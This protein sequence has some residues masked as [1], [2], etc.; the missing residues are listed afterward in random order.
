M[1]DKYLFP[2]LPEEVYPGPK[3]SDYK[4][5]VPSE[6]ILNYPASFDKGNRIFH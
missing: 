6:Y 5:P 3:D 4:L 2:I 1:V